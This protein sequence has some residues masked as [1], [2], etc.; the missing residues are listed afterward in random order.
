MFANRS[1][2]KHLGTT[3]RRHLLGAAAGSMAMLAVGRTVRALLQGSLR[4]GSFQAEV[5]P[6]LGQLVYSGAFR[7]ATSLDTPLF[8]KGFVLTG[9]PEAGA[10][11]ATAVVAAIDWC[12]IRNQAYDEWCQALADAAGTVPDCVLL[13]SIHQHDTPLGDTGAQRILA[14]AGEA[15]VICDL[16]FHHRCVR[17]AAAAAAR[18]AQQARPVTHVGIGKA[19]VEQI[20]SNRRVE[21][22]NGRVTF[23][24]YSGRNDE[25]YRA[26][27]EGEIDPYLRCVSL[28]ENDTPLVCL[29]SYATH[30][31]SVYG[32]GAIHYDFVGLAR[33]RRQRDDP[34]VMQIYASGCSG[35]VTAGKYNDGAPEHRDRLAERLYLA[36]QR[37]W[38]SSER[39]PLARVECRHAPLVLPHREAEGLSIEDLQRELADSTL[40]LQRRA[41]AAVGLSARRHQ[42]QGH[43]CDIRCLDLGGAKLLLFP[44][45]AFVHY[46][47]AAQAMRPDVAVL[48]MGYGEC[49]PGY[50]PT[51]QAT[52]EGFI[53]EH[54]YCWVADGVE[55]RILAATRE[56][57]GT[58]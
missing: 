44:A 34:G 45:E 37:A 1:A 20:A 55:E 8:I 7:P 9:T 27:P 10:A 25:L 47:L 57:L 15:S 29:S 23:N 2:I 40:P 6:R 56:A 46:Q 16:E 5:T 41:M 13:S 17:A 30:P 48:A 50:I 58:A 22:P 4:V 35:D 49:S 3:Q 39:V 53:E 12:E 26:L 51:D 14:E 19:R 18:A 43:V 54:G 36:M 42:P 32:S 21:L 24:R 38:E 11:S 31:M 28:W 33:E 52:R